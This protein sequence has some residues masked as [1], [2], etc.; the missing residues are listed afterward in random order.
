MNKITKFFKKILY[1]LPFGMKGGNEDIFGAPTNSIGGQTINQNV[2]DER[3]GKHLLKGEVT[4]SVK[5]L[6]YRTYKVDDES[7]SFKYLGNGVAVNEGKKERNLNHIKFSQE[8]KLVTSSVLDDLKHVN[9]YGTE[10]YTLDIAYNNPNVKFKLEQ[11][12]TQIDVELKNGIDGGDT[13]QFTT[14]VV[15]KLHFSSIPNGYEKKSAPFIN[16]LKNLKK[17]VDSA[18][19]DEF[20]TAIFAHSEIASSM[21]TLNFITYKATNDEPD[22]ISYS[23]ANPMLE[24]I[25][26]ENAEFILTFK[27]DY[28]LAKDLKASFY[29]ATMEK[30]YE[31]NAPKNA[32]F[33]MTPTKKRVAHCEICGKEMNTY[34]AD[35]TKSTFGK[36]MCAECLEKYLY[37]QE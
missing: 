7:K 29:D 18:K 8:C 2:A 16:E 35:I 5:E 13:S 14:Y 22:L 12:A 1:A 24:K 32:D 30:K 3:V 9:D 33:D 11:F 10:K 25:E 27:W 21:F 17:M 20:I 23:F 28:C 36:A 34:D 31:E 37:N 26:E 19:S 4:Q 15:T 6:R